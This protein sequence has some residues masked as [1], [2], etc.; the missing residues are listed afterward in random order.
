MSDPNTP[1]T[2]IVVD[3]SVGVKWSISEP[4]AAEAAAL[5]DGRFERHVPSYFYIEVAGTI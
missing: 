1:R 4:H 5:L 2:C 3:A